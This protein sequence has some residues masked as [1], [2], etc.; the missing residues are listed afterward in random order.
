MERLQQ[1]LHL[2]DGPVQSQHTI[3]VDKNEESSDDS[4]T[5]T[6]TKEH[7]GE[8]RMLKETPESKRDTSEANLLK[9]D[10]NIKNPSRISADLDAKL[11]RYLWVDCPNVMLCSNQYSKFLGFSQ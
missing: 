3:F 7:G 6:I 10:P 1:R 9:E 2:I 5:D 8:L 11:H 4:D